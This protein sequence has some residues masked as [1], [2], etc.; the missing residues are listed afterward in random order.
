MAI[1][2]VVTVC[3]GLPKIAPV[4]A[5]I[6]RFVPRPDRS[7]E[8]TV[9]R[10]VAGIE[11]V[12]KRRPRHPVSWE[13]TVERCSEP[14]VRPHLHHVAG[15]DQ[16]CSRLGRHIY[17]IVSSKHLETT[18]IILEQ[19]GQCACIGVVVES[20]ITETRHPISFGRTQQVIDRIVIEPKETCVPRIKG[21][22]QCIRVFIKA[23]AESGQQP[24]GKCLAVVQV[25]FDGRTG[26]PR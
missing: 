10:D 2:G 23:E 3:P 19:Q 8:R 7:R 24:Q 4:D 6:V 9:I 12:R 22:M 18:N 13:H 15:V 5:A 14:I 20:H 25:L 21:G 26:L 17:P 16:Y 11:E 1:I